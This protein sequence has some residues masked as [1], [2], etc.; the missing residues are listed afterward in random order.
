[1]CNC[2]RGP[3]RWDCPLACESP[4]KVLFRYG[5]MTHIYSH[6]W[7]PLQM[8]RD[9]GAQVGEAV[10]RNNPRNAFVNAFVQEVRDLAMPSDLDH[11]EDEGFADGG[12][13]VRNI[14]KASIACTSLIRVRRC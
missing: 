11:P 6:T 7:R 13:R 9:A 10:G 5:Y 3:S 2:L 1:M 4:V 14:R 12:E 8:L